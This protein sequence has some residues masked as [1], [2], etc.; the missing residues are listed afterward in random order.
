VGGAAGGLVGSLTGASVPATGAG[1]PAPEA[2]FD[3]EGVRRSGTLVTAC[4][5]DARASTAREI[6][7]R[8]KLVDP[9]LRAAAHRE[10]GWTS[11]DP[12][13]PAYTV[14]QVAA[15]RRRYIGGGI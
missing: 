5:D 12:N 7:Q 2:N 10:S 11:F 6:L 1:V 9:A 8:H 3:A 13:A 15:E 4:V 14:D